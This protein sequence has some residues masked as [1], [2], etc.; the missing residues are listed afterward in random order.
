MASLRAAHSRTGTQGN[1]RRS[2]SSTGAAEVEGRATSGDPTSHTSSKW[3]G[4]SRR[5]GG[6]D[7]MAARGA[8]GDHREAPRARCSL[9]GGVGLSCPTLGSPL[10][11]A[12]LPATPTP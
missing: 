1:S 12:P 4:G 9:P 6:R 11:R 3:G 10:G 5:V 2:P 7:N 8:S